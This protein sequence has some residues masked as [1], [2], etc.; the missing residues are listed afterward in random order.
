[1]AVPPEGAGRT[2]AATDRPHGGEELMIGAACPEQDPFAPGVSSALDVLWELVHGHRGS[3]PRRASPSGAGAARFL[4]PCLDGG[5]DRRV[6]AD[7]GRERL[8]RGQAA[9]IGGLREQTLAENGD[10]ARR[11]RAAAIGE[12]LL[13]LGSGGRD[14]RRW[15]SSRTARAGSPRTDRA[16]DRAVLTRSP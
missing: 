8:D 9:E 16:D 1:M 4:Y 3:A 5:C 12:R 10:G 6:G 2:C 13:A 15:T 7:R 14:G 11:R